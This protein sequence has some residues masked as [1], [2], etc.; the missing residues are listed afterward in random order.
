MNRRR[1]LNALPLATLALM[2]VL[3]RAQ[4][5]PGRP[6][7]LLVGAPAGTVPDV[8]ARPVAER[9]SALL[10]QPVVVENRPG[11]GGALSMTALARSA[12]D[13]YTLALATMSQAV[14]NPYLFARLAYDPIRDLEPVAPLVTGA[15]A[16]AAHPAFPARTLPEFVA[17]A[18]ARPGTLF[19]AIPQLGTPPHIV[20]LLLNR[21]TGIEVTLVPHKSGS[22]AM[23][24]VMSGEIPLL[25]DAPTIMAGPIQAGRLKALAVTGRQREP[26]LPDTPTAAESGIN[27][28]GE[29]WI[30][31]VAPKGTPAAVVQR[32]NHDLTAI[33][34][35]PDMRTQMARLGFRTLSS[36]PDEF[37]TLIR[38]EHAKWGVA[39]KEAGL[40]LE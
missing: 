4:S 12:P 34:A 35:T 14:F 22:D 5:Y 18:K 40:S 32:L 30:G 15:M 24:A 8:L 26:L 37:R 25:L 16:L 38:D 28:Q 1:I 19:V 21:V 9:L 36:T 23:N 29:T 31:L 10:G 33:M 6:V 3:S 39:I 7:L 20:A 27:L 17:L 11:A 13:G 2:P